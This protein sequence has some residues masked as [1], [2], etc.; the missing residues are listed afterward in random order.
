MCPQRSLDLR[1]NPGSSQLHQ[2]L[3]QTDWPSSTEPLGIVRLGDQ[4]YGDL[5]PGEKAHGLKMRE[6]G[7]G[8]C[9]EAPSSVIRRPRLASVSSWVFSAA[10][11]RGWSPRFAKLF[12][13]PLPKR[14]NLCACARRKRL[15]DSSHA[16]E[17]GEMYT[18]IVSVYTTASVFSNPARGPTVF[19]GVVAS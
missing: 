17:P 13:A 12:F 8:R 4:G 10:T 3:D 5:E 1:C 6:G 19:T 7:E 14:V 15:W 18:T 2:R 16:L 9:C 11:F